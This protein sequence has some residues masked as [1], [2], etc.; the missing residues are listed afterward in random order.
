LQDLRAGSAIRGEA[1][2]AGPRAGA[3][4]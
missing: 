1:L 2:T 4:E 3:N